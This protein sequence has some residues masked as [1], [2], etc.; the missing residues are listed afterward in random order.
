MVTAT[1]I[2]YSVSAVKRLLGLGD[3]IT[4]KIQEFGFVIWV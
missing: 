4:V 3:R 1:N 2:L